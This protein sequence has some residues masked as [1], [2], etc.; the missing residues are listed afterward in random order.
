MLEITDLISLVGDLGTVG[1]LF[2]ILVLGWR[3]ARDREQS[4]DVH[5]KGLLELSSSLLYQDVLN[6]ETMQHA[7]EQF[8]L[9]VDDIE[10]KT[11]ELVSRARESSN[12]LSEVNHTTS[13]TLV[14]VEGVASNLAAVNGVIKQ[15]GKTL[16]SLQKIMDDS[17]VPALADIAE[18]RAQLNS[19][20]TNLEKNAIEQ[21]LDDISKMLTDAMQVVRN[22]HSGVEPSSAPQRQ[23]P[24]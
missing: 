22:G 15:H 5:N 2:I 6:R 12:V 1:M 24:G 9:S 17:L 4:N 21:K 19:M 20:N 11:E 14:A 10:S 3:Y 16:D 8:G 7:F 13:T 23:P 18:I